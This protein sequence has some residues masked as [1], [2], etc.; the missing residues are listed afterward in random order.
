M[1]I[2]F[3]STQR[4]TPSEPL[5]AFHITIAETIV[6]SMKIINPIAV[7]AMIPREKWQ[8]L[9][10]SSNSCCQVPYIT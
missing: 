5:A 7:T 9:G 1:D 6:S 4:N 8:R 10:L 3:T 2:L